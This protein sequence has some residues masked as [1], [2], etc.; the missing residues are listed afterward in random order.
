VTSFAYLSPIFST[1]LTG[2]Y[3]GVSLVTGVWIACALVIAGAV[4]CN[5][6]MKKQKS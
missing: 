5:L 1:I 4:I 6:S 2:F 3:L